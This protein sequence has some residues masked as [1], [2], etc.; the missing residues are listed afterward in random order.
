MSTKDI[1]NYIQYDPQ[2][3]TKIPKILNP[4]PIKGCDKSI[5]IDPYVLGCWLGD[6][7]AY[8]GRITNTTNNIWSEHFLGKKV[9]YKI[10]ISQRITCGLVLKPDC[11]YY[12]VLWIQTDI[13]I[14][15]EIAM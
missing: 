7:S 14:R 4:K 6:G 12:K 1:Y 2:S 9:Y 15:P 3:K 13:T 11:S 8:E 10:N 5:D